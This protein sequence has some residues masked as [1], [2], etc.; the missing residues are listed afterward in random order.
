[1]KIHI[2]LPLV[3]YLIKGLA[4]LRLEWETGNRS[5]QKKR[6]MESLTM[7]YRPL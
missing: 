7:T 3:K 2:S 5:Y 4:K 6:W 1:M